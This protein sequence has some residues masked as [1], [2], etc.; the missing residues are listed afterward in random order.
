MDKE[1]GKAFGM[2]GKKITAEKTFIPEN[3]VGKVDLTFEISTDA[4]AG[5][6]VVAFE[7][8]YEDKRQIAV[9]ADIEDE[10]QTVRIPE[11]RTVAADGKDADKHIAA[12]KDAV[13]KDTVSLKN[14]MPGINLKLYLSGT[15]MTL[16][17]WNLNSMRQV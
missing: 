17:K 10:A 11:I 16:Q 7:Y 9:H 13:V 1:T 15:R 8:L 4:L 6:S 2:N 3:R 14:F 5:K 12:A